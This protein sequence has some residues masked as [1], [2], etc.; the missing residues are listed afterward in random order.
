MRKHFYN[1]VYR[2]FLSLLLGTLLCITGCEKDYLVINA[3]E[4]EGTTIDFKI[5]NP[6]DSIKVAVVSMRCEKDKQMN[7]RKIIEI[8]ESVMANQPKTE[9]IC[10]GE[11]I[12]AWYAE[13][14]AY[15]WSIA[16]TIPGPTT[17]LIA[18]LCQKHQIYISFGLPQTHCGKLYNSMVFIDPDGLIKAIHKKNTLTPEDEEAGYSA[19]Q[20]ARIVELKSFRFG[21]MICADVNG[22]WLTEYYLKNEI[23]V[24]LSAFASAIEAPDFNIISRRM[25]AWQIFPNRYGS[26]GNADYSGLIYVSDP[27][28]NIVAQ[29]ADKENVI[30]YTILK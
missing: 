25:N 2:I 7:Q 8:I 3:F 11:A 26:E 30:F 24:L 29:S 13:P 6:T 21:F 5:E 10:F 9:L 18:D 15:I 22:L 1:L 17:S 20:N 12:T 23:D 4:A 28:G 19:E 27:A 14:E 16:E